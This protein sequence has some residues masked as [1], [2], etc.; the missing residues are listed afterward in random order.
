M[1]SVMPKPR[2]PDLDFTLD[3]LAVSTFT[4]NAIFI[5]PDWITL[6]GTKEVIAHVAPLHSL[7]PEEEADYMM[8]LPFFSPQKMSFLFFP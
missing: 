1:A 3:L 2:T 4:R 8:K 6:I 7:P 5:Q